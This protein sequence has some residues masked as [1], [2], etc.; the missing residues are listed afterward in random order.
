[1]FKRKQ[2]LILITSRWG[3]IKKAKAIRKKYWEILI[4][5]NIKVLCGENKWKRNYGSLT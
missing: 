1:M 2:K 4:H 5:K 3:S